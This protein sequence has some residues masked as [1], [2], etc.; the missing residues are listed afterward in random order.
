MYMRDSVSVRHAQCTLFHCAL[1]LKLNVMPVDPSQELVVMKRLE[2]GVIVVI[3]V[4]TAVVTWALRGM[5]MMM[6][7]SQDTHLSHRILRRNHI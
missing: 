4:V 3:V 6:R 5:S 1:A 7:I 2:Q